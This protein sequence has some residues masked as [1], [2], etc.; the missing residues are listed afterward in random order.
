MAGLYIGSAPV[1]GL[2]I[3][4]TPVQQLYKGSTLVWSKSGVR[5]DFNRADGA[6]GATWTHYGPANDYVANI[7]N[8]MLRLDVPDGLIS[9]ALKTDRIRFNAAQVSGTDYYVEFRVGTQGSGD[10]ITGTK[11]R[12]QVFARV[13]DAAFTHGVGVELLNSKLAIVRR[14]ASTDTIMAADCGAFAAGDII[15]LSG[16]GNL[17]TLRRNG[18]FAGEWNDTGASAAS[19]TGYKSVGARVD[20]SKD[21]LGPRRFSAGIDWIEAG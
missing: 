11:H 3:G 18:Q 6:L 5:D 16:V 2:Y 21:L 9:A 19:G 15:R 14:V 7:V 1:Q 13:S 10:S 17:H 8:G 12:T 4:S 20:G